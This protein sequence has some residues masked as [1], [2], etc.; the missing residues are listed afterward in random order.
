MKEEKK[1]TKIIGHGVKIGTIGKAN[2]RWR[3][4]TCKFSNECQLDTC[5]MCREPKQVL[6][7]ATIQK[8]SVQ[9]THVP[10]R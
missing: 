10:S 7:E 6:K 9:S 8:S 1:A 2:D 4:K 3:C 5:G